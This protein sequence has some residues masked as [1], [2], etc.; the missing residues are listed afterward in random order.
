MKILIISGG[1]SAEREA[2]LQSGQYIGQALMAAGHQ[3]TY[4]DPGDD[5]TFMLMKN[6]VL[7]AEVVFPVLRG[8][9]GEDGALQSVLESLRV[10]FVGAS[11]AA[12]KS[13]YDKAAMLKTLHA[14]GVPTPVTDLVDYK[15]FIKHPLLQH[16]FVFKSRYEGS[17]GD[18]YIIRDVDLFKPTPYKPAFDLHGSMLLQPLIPGIEIS[19]GMLGDTPMSPVE[20]IVSQDGVVQ[21]VVPA[22]RVSIEVQREAQNLAAYVHKLT[23]CRHYSTTEMIWAPDGKLYCFEINVMPDIHAESSYKKAGIALGLEPPA[24]LDRLVRL[25]VEQ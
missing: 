20:T 10:P 13:C 17:V 22:E 24:L 19:V 1:S 8:R 14:N 7:D 3:V 18:T 21:H 25:A 9:G 12:T 2:S 6:F 15:H 4:F 5:V 23:G 16:P 11:S